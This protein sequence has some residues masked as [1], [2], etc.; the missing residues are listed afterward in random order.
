MTMERKL[1][2][3]MQ[4]IINQH[5]MYIMYQVVGWY[6]LKSDTLNLIMTFPY[7]WQI[8]KAQTWG[9]IQ[10]VSSNIFNILYLWSPRYN[11]YI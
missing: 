4:Y 6:N 7:L 9:K 8:V 3:K 10:K 11:L 5:G 1:L 2:G